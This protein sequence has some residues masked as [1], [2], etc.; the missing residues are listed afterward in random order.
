[1]NTFSLIYVN[2]TIIKQLISSKSVLMD[3]FL[4]LLSKDSNEK[5]PLKNIILQITLGY[6]GHYFLNLYILTEIKL[7]E[8]KFLNLGYGNYSQK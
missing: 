8:I 7:T 3:W 6:H 5:Q 2:I 4:M 1:M